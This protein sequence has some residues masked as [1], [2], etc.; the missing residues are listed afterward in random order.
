MH[1]VKPGQPP[2]PAHVKSSKVFP[3]NYV[4][5]RNDRSSFGG[6]VFILVKDNLVSIEEQRLVTNCEIEWVKIK[7][8]RNKDLYVGNLTYPTETSKTSKNMIA[9]YNSSSTLRI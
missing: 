7:L 4:A 8:P 5:Y 1:G 3:D 2:S 9:H 6:G